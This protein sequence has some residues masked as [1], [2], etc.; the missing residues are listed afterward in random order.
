M[1]RAVRSSPMS[2]AV[3]VHLAVLLAPV[4]LAIG[5][6]SAVWLFFESSREKWG[7]PLYVEPP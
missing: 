7:A 3:V 1:S 2:A 5:A 4:V 6:W